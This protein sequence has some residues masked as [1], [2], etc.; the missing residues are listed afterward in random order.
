MPVLCYSQGLSSKGDHYFPDNYQ[1]WADKQVAFVNKW[2]PR[3]VEIWNEPW[4]LP[5]SQGGVNPSGYF[6]L[7]KT[8]AQAIWA[9][10]P[11]TII[12]FSL[13]YYTQSDP[14][15]Q[16]VW[17]DLVLQADSGKFLNDPRIRPSTHN[18]CQ[19]ATPE[20]PRSNGWGFDRYKLAYNALKAHGHPNPMVHVT[21]FGWDT[22]GGTEQ[23]P[24]S[25]QQQADYTGRAL[26]MM[27]ASGIV[28][29]AYLFMIKSDDWYGVFRPDGSNRPVCGVV[30]A[31]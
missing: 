7:V 6:Q 12:V 29:A 20:D 31:L 17:Q 1:T 10:S 11:A 21:E 26:K 3:A 14:Q 27:L 13:D 2:K 23:S 8:T 9:Q 19:T 5:F 30:K 25:E 24:V 15:G 28:E 16:R 18:Y 4:L 22:F